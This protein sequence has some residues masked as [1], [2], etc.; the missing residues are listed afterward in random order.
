[1][2]ELKSSKV[3]QVKTESRDRSEIMQPPLQYPFHQQPIPEQNFYV[4]FQTLLKNPFENQMAYGYNWM[5]PPQF[6]KNHYPFYGCVDPYYGNQNYSMNHYPS[7]SN[8]LLEETIP[9]A[10]TSASLVPNNSYG[11][12]MP[13]A[14]YSSIPPNSSVA[15]ANLN[16]PLYVQ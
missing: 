1:M 9:L 10:P 14:P 15:R 8:K 6:Q 12:G 13:Y 11:L 5:N 7:Y 3:P 2:K 4:D 16:D